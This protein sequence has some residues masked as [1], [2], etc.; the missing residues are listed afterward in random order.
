LLSLAVAAVSCGHPATHARDAAGDVAIDATR[1]LPVLRATSEVCKL[2]SN[3]N[4]SDPTAN[5]VQFR[6]NVLGAD[7]GIPVATTDQLFLFFG[8]TIGFAG[9]W[10]VGQSH[11]DS[12]GYAAATAIDLPAQ[13]CS[14]LGI[15]SLPASQSIGPTV[16]A[17]VQADFAGAAMVA[18][19]GGSLADY[20]HNPAGGGGTTFPNLPGDFEVPSG[21]F[22]YGGA[23]YIFYT[24]VVSPTD[25]TM[26]GSY[27]ARWDAPAT[28]GVPSYQILYTIDERADA[29]GALGGNFI[30]IAAVAEGDYVY[31]FGTGEYRASPV[32]LARKRLD[33]LATAGSFDLTAT[34]IIATPGYGETSVRYF[35]AIDRWMFLAEEQVAGAN[36]IVARFADHAE[37][38]WSDAIV[39]HDMADAAFRASYCCAVDNDCQ[40]IAFMNCDRTGFYGTY[41]L[42]DVA[43]T[44]DGSF[45]VTYTMSSFDSYD[46]AL[47][48]ATFR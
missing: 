37:G 42:P 18:P 41:L 40:G 31:L 16:D 13:L 39:V 15:V 44:S 45:T 4:T 28:R 35:A 25:K 10:P 24:T 19:P 33:S 46:V 34:P 14:Q 12:I 11:P 22:A 27:L 6:S 5:D 1:P 30:N 21:A 43:L 17:R 3:L 48:Q 29:A 47:F 23:I 8:D 9:I 26:I 7:L 2:L 38:P 20:I 36:R 32:S